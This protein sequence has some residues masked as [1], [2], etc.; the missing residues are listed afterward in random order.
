MFKLLFTSGIINLQII[1]KA[2]FMFVSQFNNSPQ[3]ILLE[4]DENEKPTGTVHAF[5]SIECLNKQSKSFKGAYRRARHA[6]GVPTE[7][8]D[9]CNPSESLK[10]G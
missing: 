8:C 4:L 10:A 7:Q 9:T 1:R 3:R 6:E 2:Y 5:C